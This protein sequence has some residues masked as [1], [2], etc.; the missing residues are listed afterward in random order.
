MGQLMVKEF[1]EEIEYPRPFFFDNRGKEGGRFEQAVEAA[2]SLLR[3]LVSNGVAVTFATWEGHFQPT[4]SAEEMKS[5][6][7]H[8]ALIS[9]SK[10]MTGKGFDNWRTRTIKEGGGIFL[11]G[12]LPPPPS[13]PSCEVVPV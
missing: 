1:V 7:R 3:L 8:L 6:L 12:E 2:A 13:L 5:A 4:A 10:K 11:Q 9:L